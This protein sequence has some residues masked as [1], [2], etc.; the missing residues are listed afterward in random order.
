MDDSKIYWTE[1]EKESQEDMSPP[2]LD[3]HRADSVETERAFVPHDGVPNVGAILKRLRT[4]RGLSLREVAEATGLSHSFLSAVER[5]ESDIAL[6]RLARVAAFF[7]HDLGSFLG[8]TARRAELQFVSDEDHILIQRGAGIHYEVSRLPGLRMEMLLI[9][10]EPGCGFDD[11]LTHE[12]IDAMLV[13]DG[14]VIETVNG[15]DYPM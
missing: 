9:E 7:D 3:A 1:R 8:Y 13:V 10:L 12:G 4:R 6:N 5:G 2:A 14:E 11:E 15:V